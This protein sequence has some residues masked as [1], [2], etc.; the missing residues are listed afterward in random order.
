MA[1]LTDHRAQTQ[2]SRRVYNTICLKEGEPTASTDFWGTRF[3]LACYSGFMLASQP[4][5]DVPHA[6]R[7]TA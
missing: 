1:R 6:Y 3:R 4:H 7:I 2:P 5:S